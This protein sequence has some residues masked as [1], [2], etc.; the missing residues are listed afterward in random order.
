MIVVGSL[1]GREQ[2][3]QFSS[4]QMSFIGMRKHMFCQ[5]I[6][7][8]VENVKHTHTVQWSA[9][10]CRAVTLL[11]YTGRKTKKHLKTKTADK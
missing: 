11:L 10:L 5:N 8:I 3:I 2:S 7:K 6:I 4:N 1:L 9:A